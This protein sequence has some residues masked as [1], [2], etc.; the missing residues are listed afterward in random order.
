MKLIEV[1]FMQEREPLFINS[2]TYKRS[3]I[4]DPMSLQKNEKIPDFWNFREFK[5]FSEMANSGV[6]MCKIKE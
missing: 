6:K 5:G 4:K 1:L 2:K 3:C